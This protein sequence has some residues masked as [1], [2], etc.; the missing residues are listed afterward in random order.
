MIK[1]IPFNYLEPIQNWILGKPFYHLWYLYMIVGLYLITPLIIRLKEEIKEKTFFKI[2]IICLILSIGISAYSSLLWMIQFV[3]YIGYFMI[4]FSLKNYFKNKIF[5]ISIPIIIAILSW[6]S[7]F[8]ITEY[9]VKYNLF[10]KTLYFYG[11]LSPFVILS[12]ISVFITFLNLK[13]ENEVYTHLASHS[14]NIYLIHAGI[15][16]AL[17]IVLNLLELK[18]NGVWYIPLTS[19]LVFVISYIGSLIMNIV[20][21][22]VL[23]KKSQLKMLFEN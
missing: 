4:G 6:I 12:S 18:F 1:N 16:S 8:I 19:L 11:N 7:I 13:I 14:F 10:N 5:N 21:N 17:G 3:I 9:F 20:Q 23:M 2:S 22:K 15:L